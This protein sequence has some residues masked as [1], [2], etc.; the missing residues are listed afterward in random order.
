MIPIF[1]RMTWLY[2]LNL[3]IAIPILQ[4][5]NLDNECFDTDPLGYC[6]ELDTSTTITS[7]INIQYKSDDYQ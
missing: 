7:L 5:A 2:F 3:L 6:A 4:T 1:Y